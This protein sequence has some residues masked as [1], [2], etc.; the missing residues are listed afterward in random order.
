MCHRVV[1]RVV[2]CRVVSCRVVS[3]RVVSCRVV[4]CR[5]VSPPHSP[6]VCRFYPT[7]DCFTVQNKQ[8]VIYLANG[9]VKIYS[10][11]ISSL[12]AAHAKF[13]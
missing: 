2:S 9:E 6:H 5:V 4:S 8:F 3:C 11:D 12:L 1:C 7:T 10:P 13:A